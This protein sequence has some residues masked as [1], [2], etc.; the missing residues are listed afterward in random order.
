MRGPNDPLHGTRIEIVLL[1]A[2]Q[3]EL[4]SGKIRASISI[5]D[6]VGNAIVDNRDMEVDQNNVSLYLI[7]N[8][9]TRQG[10]LAAP[11]TYLARMTLVD[12]E[13]GITESIRKNVGLKK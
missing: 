4:L 10:I 9:K 1:R 3:Q 2:V 6:A 12:T 7:W 13:T 5:F 8:G 11:G